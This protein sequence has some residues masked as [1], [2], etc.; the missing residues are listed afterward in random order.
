[1]GIYSAMRTSV[2][3]MNAQSSKLSA[4]SDNIA[5]QNTTGYK[6]ASTE[7]ASLVSANNRGSYDSGS[8]TTSV[9][10]SI[11]QQGAKQY[12]TSAFDLMID[13]NGFFP[14]T[15][16]SGSVAYTRAGSFAPTVRLVEADAGTKQAVTRLVN[17]AGFELLGQKLKPDG[18]PSG[19]GSLVPIELPSGELKPNVSKSGVFKANL[20]VSTSVRSTWAPRPVHFP[21]RELTISR[22]A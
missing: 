4:I 18:T 22:Q 7:F 11:S 15:D 2:S 17:P 21:L 5:N 6:R 3:G 13:G 19:V 20:P 12:T 14:V 16:A 10:Y 8:V 1:M 9:R